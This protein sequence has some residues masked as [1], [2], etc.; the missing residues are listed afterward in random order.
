LLFEGLGISMF[1]SM[2]SVIAD[3]SGEPS[4]PQKIATGALEHIGITPTPVS[5]LVA[6]AVLIAMR[7]A[8]SLLANRQVGYTVA[9]IATDLRI[10]LIR[11]TMQARWKHYLDQSVG[12]LSNAIATEAQRASETFQVGAEMAAMFLTSLIYLAVAFAI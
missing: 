8:M 9:H 6:A 4:G 11:A 5:L 2:L 12:G 7:A 3:E 1:L 10:T